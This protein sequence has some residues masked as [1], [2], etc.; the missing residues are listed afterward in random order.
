MEIL[1]S[2]KSCERFTR[3]YIVDQNVIAKLIAAYNVEGMTIVRNVKQDTLGIFV[4]ILRI[5]T[6][7]TANNADMITNVWN[8]NLGTLVI[9]AKQ[10]KVPVVRS[11]GITTT[12]R[13]R[14]TAGPMAI[15][16]AIHIILIYRCGSI[17]QTN[18][19]KTHSVFIGRGAMMKNT[20]GSS[21]PHTH[22]KR[23]IPPV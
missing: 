6:F 23:L 4:K 16:M 12:T 11:M 13:V 14:Q 2:L 7:L 9:Y 10:E 8:V 3:H 1:L 20:A 17:V 21:H 5:A 15:I 22:Q 19:V 18:V